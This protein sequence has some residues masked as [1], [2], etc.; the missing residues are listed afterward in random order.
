[1]NDLAQWETDDVK[2]YLIRMARY[3]PNKQIRFDHSL[4]QLKLE[5]V[6][7]AKY[8]RITITDNLDWGK[9]ISGISSKTTKT[10]GFLRCNMALTP[11]H[12]K[13]VAYKTLVRPQ[14][15]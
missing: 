7:F 1:M 10:I 2:C 3:L 8:L 6:Q 5:Q 15:E 13:E 9:H 11:M 14:L 4:P 12:T